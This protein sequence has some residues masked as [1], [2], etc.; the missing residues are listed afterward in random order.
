M[1]FIGMDFGWTSVLKRTRSVSEGSVSVRVCV[2]NRSEGSV[3]VCV[4]PCVSVRVCVSEGCGVGC[5]VSE[6][7][8]WWGVGGSSVGWGVIEGGER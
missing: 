5:S 7:R 4:S 1:E 8:V 6:G 3:R 2:R